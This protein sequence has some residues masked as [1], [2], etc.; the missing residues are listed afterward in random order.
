VAL[1]QWSMD[2]AF[3]QIQQ[4]FDGLFENMGFPFSGPIAWWSRLNA[5]GRMPSDKLGSRVARVLQT[6]GDQR[7]R[8]TPLAYQPDDVD[9]ALGRLNLGLALAEQSAPAVKKVMTAL[10]NGKLKK[11]R[12]DL[13]VVK[14][15]EAGIINQEEAGLLARAEEV[16]TDVIQVDSFSLEEYM[17]GTVVEQA[18]IK[19]LR[20]KPLTTSQN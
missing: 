7:D 8:L 6:P 2:Y 16:R 3:A 20:D 13:M 18:D 5:V 4:A 15:V 11:D 14:A 10:R 1:M 9:E 19:S 17:R 12:M